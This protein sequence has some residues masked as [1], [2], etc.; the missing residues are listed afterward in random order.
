ML[1]QRGAV[2]YSLADGVWGVDQDTDRQA[3]EGQASPDSGE[4][5]PRS[6]AECHAPR[7]LRRLLSGTC[8]PM[9]QPDQ[10]IDPARY[11]YFCSLSTRWSPMAH[12]PATYPS[13]LFLPQGGY[14]LRDRCPLRGRAAPGTICS[15]PRRNCGI[16]LSCPRISDGAGT[17]AALGAVP[18]RYGGLQRAGGARWCRFFTAERRTA[19][20]PQSDFTAQRCHRHRTPVE[21]GAAVRVGTYPGAGWS[22]MIWPVP[23]GA[24]FAFSRQR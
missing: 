18:V 23:F 4:D 13:Q 9:C 22:S 12:Y 16:S 15:S 20:V 24:A 8:D 10:R 17:G 19:G 5:H 3:P 14:G 21:T 2:H 1:L 11:G 6:K 7:D